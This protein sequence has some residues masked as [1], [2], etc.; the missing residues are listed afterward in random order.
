M[1]LKDFVYASRMLRKSPLF[2]LAA[3]LTIGL[4]VGAS[5]AIFS[6]TNAVLLRQ[7]PYRNPDRL[8]FAICDLRKRDVKDFPFSN[9]DY[10]DLKNGTNAVFEEI[11][12]V[13][14]G[15]GSV[16]RDDGTSEQVR[17]AN[18]S[19]NFFQMMGARTLAGRP[20]TEADGT[21]PPAPDPA[22]AAQNPPPPPVPAMAILSYDYWQRRFG[23]RADIIG[24]SL[25]GAG[26]GATEIV[27]VLAPGFELL[28]P[29]EANLDRLPDVWFA[30]RVRYDNANR[31][32]VQHRLIARLRDGVSIE[33]AQ[34]IADRISAETR[35]NFLISGTAGYA[36][37]LE[38]LHHHLVAEVR[39]ALLALTGAVIF[40]LLIACVNVA[41]LLLVRASLRE[42]EYAV[43]TAL[44][45]NRWALVRQSMAEAALL[46]VGG[47]AI[48]L[49]LAWGGIRELRALAPAELP[50]LDIVRIDPVVVFFALAAS[51][52]AAAIFGMVPAIRA[53]KPDVAQLL[54]GSGRTTG[55]SAS[56]FLRSAA[57]VTEV[58][59]SFV[60]LI[61]SGLMLRSFIELQ[62]VA[63]GFDAH[64]LLTF[65]VLGAGRR[66]PQPPE[67]RAAAIRD[68]VSQLK[69]IPGIE[70]VTAST[71]FPLTG[72][73]SPIRW[74]LEAALSDPT[75]FQAVDFQIVL[76]GYFETM[77]TRILE[78]RAFNDA[79]N[80]PQ[81]NVVVIDTALAAKAYPGQSAIGKRLLI[82][83]RTPQPEWVEV[84]GVAEHQ[85]TT[86][87]SVAG[88]E[89]MYFTDGFVGHGAVG[90]WA[91][92]TSGD[93][94][95]YA[96]AARAAILR[97]DPKA[98]IL[99]LRPMDVV[100]RAAQAGTRFQMLLIAVFATI[101][102][103]LAGIGLYGV[104]STVVRQRTPE[105]GVRMALGAAPSMIFRLV[106]GQ[107]L[108]LSAMGIGAGLIAASIFTQAM[109][110]MLV[111]VRPT[112][113]LTF[114]AMALLFFVIAA[115][116]SW[117]PARRA[118]SL[119]P[120]IALR[121]E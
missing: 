119:D 60:L 11:G 99:E 78:G 64:H 9:A 10:L 106:V 93:P 37:R 55:L 17:F 45:G 70:S 30:A 57:V 47:A 32:Q 4:G 16:P 96:A 40:L 115:I 34:D 118:A 82:R 94:A 53:S 110:T 56:G 39:P 81:R 1:L 85:R 3:I 101:A 44:G 23:G 50:R 73:F 12:A 33:Q 67:Q 58:A 116:A 62:R 49:A 103:L 89:Q 107:G 46:A 51:L 90:R 84:I 120:T 31:N 41:N 35:K 72:G 104:L 74:G 100:V 117:L 54:R 98:V 18:V 86:S 91:L 13:S 36:I 112:D 66:G 121:D 2:T 75:K 20:F 61:G 29:T 38:P 19:T 21:A 111:G 114:A 15:R 92:R 48:G 52:V 109:R 5:T 68:Q 59:L 14:T 22:Q 76:P 65:Q 83:V 26:Q 6:V 8:V 80:S 108:S 88:R 113:P 63:P 102:A 97:T 105:I 87:L 27:G 95:N 69:S 7:L 25:P 42:R 71:P 43:R 77:K 79:D 24:R 28:F